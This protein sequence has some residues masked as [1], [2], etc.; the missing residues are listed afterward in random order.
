MLQN[1]CKYNFN[2]D[3]TLEKNTPI[4]ENNHPK[5][6]A[7]NAINIKGQHKPPIN[8]IKASPTLYSSG[9]RMPPNLIQQPIIVIVQTNPIIE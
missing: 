1:F 4:F 2:T 7:I 6:Q 9:V 3:V 8:A 5:L